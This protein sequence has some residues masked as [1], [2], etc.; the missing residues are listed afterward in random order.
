MGVQVYVVYTA[1]G[2]IIRVLT[3]ATIA[4]DLAVCL[5]TYIYTKQL[6]MSQQA[7]ISLRAPCHADTHGLHHF[8]L[9][10][11]LVF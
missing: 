4:A 7:Y 2:H 1:T 9:T 5:R 3:C 11:T 8:F 10:R 6:A